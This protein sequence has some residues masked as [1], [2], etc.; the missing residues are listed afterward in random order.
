MCSCG[1]YHLVVSRLRWPSERFS[2]VLRCRTV[3]ARVLWDMLPYS[4]YVVIDITE[5][6]NCLHLYPEDGVSRFFL[7]SLI[8]T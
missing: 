5:E 2:L 4:L 1:S 8:P 7:N 3:P 6:L